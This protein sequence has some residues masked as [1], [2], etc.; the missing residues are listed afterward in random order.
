MWNKRN[1]N[2]PTLS[3]FLCPHPTLTPDSLVVKEKKIIKEKGKEK[4]NRKRNTNSIVCLNLSVNIKMFQITGNW[5]ETVAS[6][7]Y[8]PTKF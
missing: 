8:R 2:A 5:F 7:G 1:M 3:S 4:E 6:V